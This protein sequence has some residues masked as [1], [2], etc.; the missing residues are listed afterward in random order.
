MGR[1]SEVEAILSSTT[2]TLRYFAIAA[3]CFWIQCL[4]FP[5]ANS[6]TREVA[7]R[8]R[9][10]TGRVRPVVGQNCSGAGLCSGLDGGTCKYH[11]TRGVHPGVNR[12]A[13]TLDKEIS[14]SRF[15]LASYFVVASHLVVGCGEWTLSAGVCRRSGWGFGHSNVLV[16]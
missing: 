12:A 4:G 14:S 13:P 2:V 11:P 9:P 8:R 15:A 10:P 5:F 6:V 1:C 16:Y 7:A 3:R